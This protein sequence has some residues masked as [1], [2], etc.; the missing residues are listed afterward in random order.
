MVEIKRKKN[1]KSISRELEGIA[2]GG[3]VNLAGKILGSGIFFIYTVVIVRFLGPELFGLYML[4]MTIFTF[5]G[6]VCRLG[7]DAGV[8]KFIS[9]YHGINDKKRIKGTIISA[10][11]IVLPVSLL[12]IPMVFF[13]SK[14]VF[15]AVFCKPELFGVVKYLSIALP[16]FSVMHV[17]LGFTQGFKKMRYFV[18]GHNLLLP[19]IN[20][21]F[22]TIFLHLGFGLY[23]VIFAYVMAVAS[24]A[25]A[26]LFFVKKCFSFSDANKFKFCYMGGELL[27]VSIPLSLAFFLNFLAN[28]T[29]TLMIGFF[30]LS[31]D[32]GI[33]TAAMK[34]ALLTCLILTSLNSIFA[35]FVS[36]LHNRGEIK[37]LEKLFK[38]ITR[39]IFT[40]RTGSFYIYSIR[41]KANSSSLWAGL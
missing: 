37:K 35:P 30:K 9:A 10:L 40:C 28:W 31:R 1:Q 39:W 36:D 4:G 14:P 6:I 34:T 5:I 20:L 25:I 29:D 11:L 38:I 33:Y 32:V 8:V 41:I 24:V 12:I 15:D 23:G 19:T 22:A 21:I 26:S 7:L 17:A 2:G 3:A 18:Y 13:F 16:F 27:R